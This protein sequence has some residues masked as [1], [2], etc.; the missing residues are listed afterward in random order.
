MDSG[1]AKKAL[2]ECEK[3]LR[4]T[5]DLQCAKGLKGLA[6]LRLG[7]END[8]IACLDALVNEKPCEDATLQAI[9]LCYRELQQ[10]KQK[11][12]KWFCFKNN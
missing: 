3:V 4:K 2:Q 7:K 8:A 1:N 5:P 9:S 11:Q 10:C 12:Q 6:L